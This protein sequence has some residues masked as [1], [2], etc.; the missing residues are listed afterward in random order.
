[1]ANMDDGGYFVSFINECADPIENIE[2]IVDKKVK[3]IYK[4]NEKGERVKVKFTQK[5]DLV[6]LKEPSLVLQP[7]LLLIY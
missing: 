5:G 7:V 1:M 2:L 3:K 4:L 6:T